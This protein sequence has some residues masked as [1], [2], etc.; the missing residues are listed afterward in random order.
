M[1]EAF[2]EYWKTRLEEQPELDDADKT[3]AQM[4]FEAAYEIEIWSCNFFK[5]EIG[6]NTDRGIIIQRYYME[7]KNVNGGDQNGIYY[8]FGDGSSCNE[9]YLH[10]IKE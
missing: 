3:E 1:N 4:A 10:K 9:I 7:S 2:K 6:D 5:Y 8:V